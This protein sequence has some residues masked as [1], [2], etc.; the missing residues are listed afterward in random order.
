MRL[1]V[2][3]VMKNLSKWLLLLREGV[4][5]F[6]SLVEANSFLMEWVPIVRDSKM[7][8]EKVHSHKN[9]LMM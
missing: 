1:P 3:P 7:K 8:S 2:L 9:V 4:F 6:F 5:F